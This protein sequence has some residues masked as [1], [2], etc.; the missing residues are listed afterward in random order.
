MWD[1][2]STAGLGV[3]TTDD[4]AAGTIHVHGQ[5]KK[6]VYYEDDG[7]AGTQDSVENFINGYIANLDHSA[8]RCW[9]ET[10]KNHAN[11]AY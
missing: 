8:N 1:Y 7:T 9:A 5:N 11:K 2:S 3:Q 10:C 6:W 4:L